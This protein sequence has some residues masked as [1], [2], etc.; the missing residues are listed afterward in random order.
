MNQYVE[1][2]QHITA[3]L[4]RPELPIDRSFRGF[5]HKRG[6]YRGKARYLIGYSWT[7]V[8]AHYAM[9]RVYD[10]VL[11]YGDSFDAALENAKARV[12]R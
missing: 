5:F 11:G 6:T 2:L 3:E 7:R 12:R 4:P 8:G 1:R 9:G 10:V